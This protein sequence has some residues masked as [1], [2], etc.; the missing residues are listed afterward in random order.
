MYLRVLHG[1]WRDAKLA[2][3]NGRPCIIGRIE[4]CDLTLAEDMVSR[5][6]TSL[7][8][9]GKI[10]RVQDLES[11]NG[12]FVNGQ[13]VTGQLDAWDGD[14]LL[15]GTSI[16]RLEPGPLAAT[17]RADAWENGPPGLVPAAWH[18]SLDD[19]PLPNVLRLMQTSKKTGV[20]RLSGPT[21]EDSVTLRKGVIVGVAV[22]RRQRTDLVMAA[23][24]LLTRGGEVTLD[25]PND[26]APLAGVSIDEVLT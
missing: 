18:I 12:T 20:L 8:A 23:K 9:V 14:I 21:G 16:A 6:H 24:H 17:V 3:P 11:T 10:V 26:D 13:R 15:V 4:S 19:V 7:T 22:G 25:P 1:R 5:A 2:L